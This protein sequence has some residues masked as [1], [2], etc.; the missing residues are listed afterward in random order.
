M[1]TTNKK[2]VLKLKSGQ[3]EI[4]LCI[5]PQTV[6]RVT[7]LAE[8][9]FYNDCPFHRV[10]DQFMA[11]TGDGSNH[12]GTGGSSYPDLEQEF[13][14]EPH[15]RGIV[16]MARAQSVNSANSQFFI[17][18]DTTPHLDRQYTV[19][20][21]VISGMDHIDG[22]KKGTDH[23]GVVHAP[24]MIEEAWVTDTQ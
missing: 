12:N 24:D 22:L 3:V 2:L 15:V 10:I 18:Y 14:D 6:E 13:S 16:S 1:S 17:C 20:G 9:G 19:F 21:K 8:E 11:Q 7:M 23:S 4:E 5:S